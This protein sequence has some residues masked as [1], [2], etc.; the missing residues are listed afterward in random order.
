MHRWVI[1]E[2]L[3]ETTTTGQ[4][5]PRLAVTALYDSTDQ[6]GPDFTMVYGSSFT[7]KI[8]MATLKT[9]FGIESI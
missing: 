1:H 2:F 4:R 6:R 3:K 9:G 5:D 7:S 8:M